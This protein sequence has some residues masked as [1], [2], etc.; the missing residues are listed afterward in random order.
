MC[1]KRAHEAEEKGR[2]G[3]GEGG[4]KRIEGKE[5]GREGNYHSITVSSVPTLESP[6]AC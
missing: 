6:C 4:E 5:R 3:G 1:E 2:E